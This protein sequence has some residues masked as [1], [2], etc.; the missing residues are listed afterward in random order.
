MWQLLSIADYTIHIEG[1]IYFPLSSS[2]TRYTLYCTVAT[3]ATCQ[4]NG[5]VET[6]SILFLK[7]S[8]AVFR[9][10]SVAFVVVLSNVCIYR[11]TSTGCVL[12]AKEKT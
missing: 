2:H 10:G 1:T 6:D 4:T 9:V 3:Q 7:L 11:K 5:M 8:L 12:S